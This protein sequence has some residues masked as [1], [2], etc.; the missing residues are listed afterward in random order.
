MAEEP[1]LVVDDNPANLELLSWV[2]RA[3]GYTVHTATD[4]EAMAVVLQTVRPRL[5]LMDI[6]LPGA[7]GLELTRR[8][9]SAPETQ[10]IPIVAVTASAM[11]GDERR[12]L[13][14]GCDAYVAKPIDV[15]ALRQLIAE[16]LARPPAP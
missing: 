7:S 11:K 5:I 14:A 12:I 6:Q 1:I 15:R 10:D 8:L 3:R 4:G 13:A 16:L 2:L 9:K